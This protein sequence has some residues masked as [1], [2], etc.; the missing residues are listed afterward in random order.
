MYLPS[1]ISAF[2]PIAPVKPRRSAIK[3]AKSSGEAVT[4]QTSS[5]ELKCSFASSIVPCQI[6]GET[7]SL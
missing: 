6:D 3:F 7:N 4:S 2:V 5:P 1:L